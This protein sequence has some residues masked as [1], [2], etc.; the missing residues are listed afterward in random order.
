ML[1][2]TLFAQWQTFSMHACLH[3]SISLHFLTFKAFFLRLFFD[4]KTVL[5]ISQGFHFLKVS[6]FPLPLLSFPLDFLLLLSSSFLSVFLFYFYISAA[7]TDCPCVS[8]AGFWL[9]LNYFIFLQP[10]VLLFRGLEPRQ[11][12][13]FVFVGVAACLM[14]SPT[15]AGRKSKTHAGTRTTNELTADKGLECK[16]IDVCT[17][18]CTDRQTDICVYVRV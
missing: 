8:H 3:A 15:L 9:A 2:G 14:S 10:S 16:C 17:Y 4:K 12:S 6:L 11:K 18:I 1:V 5:L 13:T 7:P